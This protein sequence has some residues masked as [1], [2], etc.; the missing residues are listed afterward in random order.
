M[1]ATIRQ[2]ADNA[3]ATE[4]LAAKTA[5][6]ADEGSKAVNESVAAMS[7]IVEKINI[8]D[9][10]ARQTNLLALNAAIEAA[11]AGEAGKGFAVVASEVRKL[12]ERSGSAAGEITKLSKDSMETAR[13]AGEIIEVIVPNVKKTASLVQEIAAASREQGMGIE[14]I[15]K[16]MMQLDTVVQQN[17][18]AS[19]ELASMSEELSGQSEQL[20][21]AIGFF[22]VE[23]DAEK[24]IDK[25]SKPT[26][27]SSASASK[28]GATH[29][30]SAAIS[31]P[32]RISAKTAI[33]PVDNYSDAEFEAF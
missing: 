18:S 13:R 28:G 16:A 5:Q 11:R 27:A 4:A 3:N 33:V 10:I 22:T 26:P 32:K 24:R 30:S 8:I 20:S 25:R 17:A 6:D 14:Q 15:N 31:K 7:G 23:Q 2:N 19:E 9:D 29:A 12:A 21:A 1:A